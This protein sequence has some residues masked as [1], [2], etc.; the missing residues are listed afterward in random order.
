[1][2]R[3]RGGSLSIRARAAVLRATLS[4]QSLKRIFL[5]LEATE[6]PPPRAR[7]KSAPERWG[8]IH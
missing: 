5:Q 3:R 1:M 4:F 2:S 8:G 7:R 6:Q